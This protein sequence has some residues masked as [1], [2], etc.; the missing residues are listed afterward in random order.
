[1]VSAASSTP[2][3]ASASA[4]ARLPVTSSSKSRRSNGNDTPKSNAAGSGAESNLPD[5]SGLDMGLIRRSGSRE[6]GGFSADEVCR[7]FEEPN[8]DFSGHLFRGRVDICIEADAQGIEPFAAINRLDIRRGYRCIETLLRFGRDKT[9][10]L[11]VRDVQHDGGRRFVERARPAAVGAPL[12]GSS[13]P[14]PCSPAMV[15]RLSI[16]SMKGRVT[17]RRCRPRRRARIPLRRAPDAPGCRQG[18]WSS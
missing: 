12:V 15:A 4:H 3:R 2:A 8:A 6:A 10:Q 1:M 14:T 11:G 5:H 17:R 13:R 9:P 7:P 16:I 18:A